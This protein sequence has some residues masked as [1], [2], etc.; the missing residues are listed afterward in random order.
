LWVEQVTIFLSWAG[1]IA[2]Q[3]SIYPKC[4][5][6]GTQSAQCCTQNIIKR[7]RQITRTTNKIKSD[8]ETKKKPMTTTIPTPSTTEKKG[9]KTI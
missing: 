6:C 9:A 1:S 8:K 5:K 3:Q 2:H 4:S 7:E